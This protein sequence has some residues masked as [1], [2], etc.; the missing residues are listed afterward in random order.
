[1]GPDTTAFRVEGSL[2]LPVR[3]DTR[4]RLGQGEGSQA[5]RLP[6]HVPAGP[7]V[8][9]GTPTRHSSSGQDSWGTQPADAVSAVSTRTSP[10]SGRSSSK[11]VEATSILSH[12][13]DELLGQRSSFPRVAFYQ[14][15]HRQ[16]D[17]S[18]GSRRQRTP[19]ARHFC[20]AAPPVRLLA[21]YAALTRA[22]APANAASVSTM[23]RRMIS[24]T[25][26]ISLM[27]PAV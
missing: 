3:A 11:R 18:A 27:P 20:S 1:V 5:D 8:T 16:Q 10:P 25:G 13:T 7:S 26:R 24:A 17:C 21:H 22:G 19:R 15:G 2:S 6:I 14:D 4:Q 12:Q 9:G 23:S